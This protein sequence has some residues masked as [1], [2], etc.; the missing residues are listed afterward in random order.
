MSKIPGGDI[1]GYQLLMA[2]PDSGDTFEIVFDTVKQ[3]TQVTEYLVSEP[4][5]TLTTGAD[6]RFKVLAYNFNGPSDPSDVSY[7]RVC[8]F[9]S[10][11]A[12]PYKVDTDVSTPSIT[13]GW[14]APTS[15]GGC[16]IT[17]YSVY[18]DD[19]ASGDF[20]EANE[21]NDALVRGLPTLRTLEI[22][23]ISTVGA[24][25]RV[26]VVAHNDAGELESPILGL[27]LAT[28]PDQAP[29]PA[30]VTSSSTMTAVD[31]SDY[32]SVSDGGCDIISYNV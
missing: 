8:G 19:G 24:T 18:V 26:K 27:I 30:L 2:T 5:Y 13:V 22:T 9:P 14:E 10:G 3:S 21:D 28:L 25:Y 20:V 6:Y 32:S 31:I 11:L 15:D 16:E 23:R 12:K 1:T 4:D 29:T 7:I 17:G